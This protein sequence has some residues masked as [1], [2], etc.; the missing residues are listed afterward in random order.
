MLEIV[1]SNIAPCTLPAPAY[2]PRPIEWHSDAIPVWAWISWPHRATE[3]IEAFARGW[4]DRVV[5]VEWTAERGT[6][7]TVVWRNAVT[8]RD[9]AARRLAAHPGPRAT[10][11]KP[12]LPAP[13][14]PGSA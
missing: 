5:I 3:R 1:V 12:P 9:T 11:P 13:V 6:V 4:N 14:R 7:S 8:R 2:G 10:G